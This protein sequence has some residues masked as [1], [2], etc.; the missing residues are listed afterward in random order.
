MSL[1]I[2]I[3]SSCFRNTRWPRARELNIEEEEPGTYDY[4]K[5][6]MVT[7]DVIPIDNGYS[8]AG[9]S[10]WWKNGAF[11]YEFDTEIVID[12]LKLWTQLVITWE[13]DV[14][15]INGSLIP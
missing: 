13:G 7:E 10:Y 14:G 6:I 5:I 1:I 8:I 3:S 9:T 11:T 2:S 15:G 12:E 4:F